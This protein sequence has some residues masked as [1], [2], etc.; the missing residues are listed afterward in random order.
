[1]DVTQTQKRSK[2]HHVVPQFYLR[3]WANEEGK[4]SARLRSGKVFETGTEALAVEKDFY[5]AEHPDGSKD[6]LVENALSEVDG[7]AAAVHAALLRQ[8][9]PLEPEQKITF[10]VWLGLQWVRGRSSRAGGQE[11]ADKLQKMLIRMGLENAEIDP[12]ENDAPQESPQVPESIRAGESIPVPDLSHLTPK[13]RDGVRRDLDNVQFEMPRSLILL[14]MLE[15]MAPAAMPFLEAE[16]HLLRFEAPLLF[17]SDEPIILQRN[18]SP[19]NRFLGVGPATADQ[20]YMPLSPTLCLA[21]V[22]AGSIGR[23][24][25]NQVPPG[26]AEKINDSTV[27]TWWSQLFKHVDGPEFPENVPDLPDERIKVN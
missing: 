14:Q 13:E 26:E 17:T 9:F 25:V 24:R 16:W 11:L 4:I 1:V 20:M 2:A 22:R 8:E 15:M 12:T 10:S 23:Q 18:P 7:T 3:A 5:T 19:E 6:A 21:I 27:R